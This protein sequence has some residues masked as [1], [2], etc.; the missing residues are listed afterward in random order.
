MRA[1]CIGSLLALF[2][3][4]AIGSAQAPPPSG[5]AGPYVAIDLP[6]GVRSETIFMRYVLDDDFGG[7]L[8]PRAGV[9]SYFISTN[10]Q[11]T[12]AHRFRALIYAPGCM[13]QTIDL[14]VASPEVPRYSFACQPLRTVT[15]TGMLIKPDRFGGQEINVQVKYVARWAQR[16]LGLDDGIVTDIPLGMTQGASANSAFLLSVPDLSEDSLAGAPER[17]GEFQFWGRNPASGNIAA[18]I[19]PTGR[20]LR[21]RM[22]GLRIRKEYPDPLEFAP[23]SAPHQNL[24]PR[25]AF[26]FA[27]RPDPSGPADA[28]DH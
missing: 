20:L 28:C 7:W 23:C 18:Q 11:G 24:Q 15:L 9:S 21:T 10:R 17:P 4:V 12:P 25:D 19:I 5:G 3:E 6:L 22:G 26:G 13:I 1:R 8:Q 14:R 27:I 2:L 16:F